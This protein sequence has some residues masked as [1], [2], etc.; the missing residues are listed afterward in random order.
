MIYVY[1]LVLITAIILSLIAYYSDKEI[2]PNDIKSQIE[3][4]GIK[5]I[6][7]KWRNSHK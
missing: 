3:R 4:N 5:E 1:G 7:S 6:E 2:P